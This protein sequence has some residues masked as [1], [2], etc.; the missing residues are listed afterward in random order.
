MIAKSGQYLFLVTLKK[1]EDRESPRKRYNEQAHGRS[2]LK[3]AEYMPRVKVA[4]VSAYSIER[5]VHL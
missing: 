4:D 3:R 1:Q 5:R 2:N